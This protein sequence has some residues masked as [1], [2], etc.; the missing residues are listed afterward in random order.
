MGKEV[1]ILKGSVGINNVSDPARLKFDS[2]TGL[3]ELQTAV[4]V[5]IDDTGRISRRKSTLLLTALTGA[6]S[7]F[8]YRDDCLIAAAGSLYRV[9]PDYTLLGLRAGMHQTAKISY[10]A[11]DDTIYYSN[12]YE[13]G[14]I[15]LYGLSY[16]W[17][18]D[19][20]LVVTRSGYGWDGSLG[21]GWDESFKASWDES[22]GVEEI[23][24]PGNEYSGPLDTHKYYAPPV[25]HL[26]MAAHGRMYIADGNVVWESEP[27]AYSLFRMSRGFYQFGSRITMM[28]PV[29][30]GFFV[31]DQ[32]GAYFIDLERNKIKVSSSRP[33][34]GSSVVL[35]PN[36][37]SGLE[38]EG[39]AA[40]WSSP[41]GL[42]IGTASG[43][44]VNI[45]QDKLI[46]PD[47]LTEGSTILRPDGFL[48]MSMY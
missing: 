8:S 40:L 12:G 7:M 24:S 20:N 16:T 1:T 9:S 23:A 21:D 44:V 30:G 45:T 35:A 48:T 4:N 25:G 15:K 33:Y 14:I 3:A 27:F 38:I 31:G 34:Q 2:E 11:I 10:A 6:H 37:L 13:N 46:F 5:E 47:G 36:V 43:S 29:P 42:I 22:F 19:D 39:E 28:V 41:G 18:K 32:D 17:V 26:L